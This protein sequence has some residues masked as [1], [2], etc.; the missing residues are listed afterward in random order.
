M[1]PTD[2][3]NGRSQPATAPVLRLRN[4]T[5]SG[6]LLP[7]CCFAWLAHAVWARNGLTWDP[8]LLHFIHRYATPARDKLMVTVTDAGDVRTVIILAMLGALGLVARQCRKDAHFL[9]RCIVGTVILGVLAKTV[10]HRVRPHFWESPAPET[11]FGFPSGH[12]MHSLALA[13]ALAAI[14]WHT[15]WR[16]PV[17]LIGTLYVLAVGFS[18][19]YLGVHYPSDVLGGW[20]LAMAWLVALSAFRGPRERVSMPTL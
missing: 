12:S 3:S 9:A 19:L 20:A 16:W 5:L 13:F 17:L 4:W 8:S 1:K 18:R 11:D 10:F 2:S 14:F 7:L 6:A 15:H